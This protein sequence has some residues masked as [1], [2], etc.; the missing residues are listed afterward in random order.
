[1]RRQRVIAA[2]ASGMAILLG[3]CSAVSQSG[4]P[5]AS[6]TAL[7][8]VEPSLGSM[9]A[10]ATVRWEGTG[11]MTHAGGNFHIHALRDGRVLVISEE[12]M[13]ELWDPTTGEWHAVEGLNNPRTGFASVLLADGRV[14][15]VGGL[16]DIGQSYSSAY[17]FDP[18]TETWDK[19][20]G[21]MTIARTNPA[22]A[23]L[24][25]GRVL[26]AGGY[27]HVD[28]S[29]GERPDGIIL[30]A[31]R[32]KATPSTGSGPGSVDIVPGPYGA[33]MATAEIFDPTTGEW[34][35]TGSMRF[36]RNGAEATPL[37]DG[38]V[39]V[40]GSDAAAHTGVEVAEDSGRTAEIYDPGT[41][42][43]ALA[44]ELPDLNVRE[45]LQAGVDPGFGTSVLGDLVPL[46][47]G[48][49]VLINQ[50]MDFKH[51][52][53]GTRSLRFNAANREWNQIGQS[54]LSVEDPASGAEYR[55]PGA[56]RYDATV[57]PLAGGRVLLAGGSFDGSLAS[58]EM[59]D[60]E[61]NAFVALPDMPEARS[62]ALGALLPDGSVL[63]TGGFVDQGDRGVPLSSA[64][65]LLFE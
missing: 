30:A 39:L 7:P 15:V 35:S 59:F 33:A 6:P 55:S 24:P 58:A 31:F 57:V 50:V 54:H 52:G 61:T 26:V 2:M 20:A 65:R 42:R 14:L 22:A 32:P 21:L 18:A 12:Q 62:H 3:G 53:R 5:G 8:S 34:S 28:P 60:P 11:S 19:A 51:S 29:V 43:F 41:G 48:G 64:V 4:S 1:M 47:D 44:G 27:F 46:P 23:L 25:D 36:A 56:A 63:I 40:V 13:A 17:L 10:Q 37:A 16:N 38:R 9:P 45:A 49:A